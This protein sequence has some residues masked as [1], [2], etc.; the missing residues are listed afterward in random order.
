MNLGVRHYAPTKQLGVKHYKPSQTLG[1]R[2]Y[3][4]IPSNKVINPRSVQNIYNHYSNS[5]LVHRMPMLYM[6]EDWN[7]RDP[8]S[9]KG[10]NVEKYR[11]Q[12]DS[13]FT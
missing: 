2:H 3:S 1:V 7:K 5:E 8:I 10:A 9:A 13:K 12:K 4:A 11:K 6:S